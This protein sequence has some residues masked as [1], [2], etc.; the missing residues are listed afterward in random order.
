MAWTTPRT[1]V[2]GET[3][4]ATLMN[5]QIRDNLNL[6]KTE[7]TDNGAILARKKVFADVTSRSSPSGAVAA[8]GATAQTIPGGTLASAGDYLRI[9]AFGVLANNGN[10]K[11]LGMLFGAASALPL[12]ARGDQGYA[13]HLV[14]YVIRLTSTTQLVQAHYMCSGGVGNWIINA[15]PPDWS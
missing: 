1:W 11:N 8:W 4:S 2:S 3:V 6:L 10:A 13:F 7:I 15:V 14:G 9:E 12:N 5:A